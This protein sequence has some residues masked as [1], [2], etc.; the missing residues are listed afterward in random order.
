MSSEG[1]PVL[2]HY[3]GISFQISNLDLLQQLLVVR[4]LRHQLVRQVGEHESPTG[5]E[6]IPLRAELRVVQPV[7][8]RPVVHR[9]LKTR[10]CERGVFLTLTATRERT[11]RTWHI[12]V[13]A[14]A[15]NVRREVRASKLACAHN[16]WAP[17]VVPRTET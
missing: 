5:V 8:Q 2:P 6:R 3:D 4:I 11:A 16:L 14:R 7:L 1:L 13:C 15:K 17:A 9:P 12:R 10:Q